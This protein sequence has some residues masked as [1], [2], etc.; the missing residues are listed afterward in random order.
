MQ[1]DI[2][3]IGILRGIESGFFG[4]VMTTSFKAG[5]QAIEVTMNTEQ[6]EHIV[7]EN[8][9]N[10]PP[11]R[12]LGMGTIRNLEEAKRA[13]EAGAMYLVTPNLD[14]DVIAYSKKQGIPI[15]AGALTP[16]EVYNAWSAGAD[17][18][19]V[20]PCSTFGGPRHIRELLGPFDTIPLVAVGG[21][22]LDNLGDYF[23]AGAKAV[24]VSSSLFGK[25]ALQDKNLDKLEKNVS[26]FIERCH[27]AKDVL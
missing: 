9:A 19:K 16:S 17:M 4:D 1:L 5:L 2:P 7:A 11:G 12:F 6:A 10:V 20:F 14:T 18:V 8:I 23:V 15:V 24:G 22:T 25:D 13:L 3:V 27:K 26:M 21:V